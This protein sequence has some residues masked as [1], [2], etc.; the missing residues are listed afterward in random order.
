VLPWVVRVAWLVV[1]FTVGTA[2]A[3]ALDDRSAAVQVCAAVILWL[4]WSGIVVGLL[5]PRPASLVGLRVGA[6]S[7]AVLTA[8]SADTGAEWALSG[9][10]AL[11]V[12]IVVFAP[13]TGEWLVN[14][15]SYGY[16]RRYLLRA[17]AAVMAG[18]MLLAAL[19]LPAAVA[20][21]PLLLA[22]RQWVAGT[23][24]VA[25]GAGLAFVVARALHSMAVRWAV[26]VPAGLVIKDHLALLDPV[27][28]RRVDIEV[29]RP[30]PAD[31][32]GL[33]LTAGAL[34]LALEIRLRQE[35]HV[36][37]MRPVRRGAEPFEAWKLLFTP[38][39]SKALLA[40]A[41]GRK[42]KAEQVPG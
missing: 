27:L 8:W 16:E 22:A 37:R 32:D 21:G 3:S 4:G 40:D 35:Q 38:T 31:T 29:L 25:A 39:R 6:L 33:D 36:D 2:V 24:A 30:A 28:F 20:A 10:T 17:P 23:V 19:A 5:V 7:V 1:P 14:G 13:L 15:T 12:C 9:L 26:L 41:A 34:G 11:A 18:P 42:I